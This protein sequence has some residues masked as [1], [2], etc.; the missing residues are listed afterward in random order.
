MEKSLVSNLVALS[1]AGVIAAACDRERPYSPGAPTVLQPGPTVA[2]AKV[3]EGSI[4]GIPTPNTLIVAGST[5]QLGSGAIIRSGSMGVTFAD[6]R[7][8]ARSRVTGESDGT[9]LMA[10][11]VELLD[12]VGTPLVL[13]GM[14]TAVIADDSGFRFM[15]GNQLVRGDGDTQVLEG[16]T[17]V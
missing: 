13:R 1:L 2:T 3:I 5:V 11:L 12:P 8:G 17:P 14:I 9:V 4:E 15:M 7:I 16:T 6:L 10:S